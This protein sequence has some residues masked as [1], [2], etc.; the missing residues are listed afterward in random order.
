MNTEEDD[1]VLV[2]WGDQDGFG[3]MEGV[4]FFWMK[5]PLNQL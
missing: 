1:L 5:P 4:L 3:F 2:F